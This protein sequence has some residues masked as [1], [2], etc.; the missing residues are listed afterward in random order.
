ML[1]KT[2]VLTSVMLQIALNGIVCKGELSERL[3]TGFLVSLV[4]SIPLRYRRFPSSNAAYSI[5]FASIDK[6]LLNPED[7]IYTHIYIRY[8]S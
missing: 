7:S 4:V 8:S 2:A 5:I 3:E 1:P 6:K